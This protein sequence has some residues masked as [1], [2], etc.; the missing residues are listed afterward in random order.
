MDQP[1]TDPRPFRNLTLI[2][3]IACIGVLIGA[4]FHAQRLLTQFETNQQI[5]LTS[6]AT[7]VA[8]EARR[9]TNEFSHMLADFGARVIAMPEQQASSFLLEQVVASNVIRSLDVIDASGRIIASSV[10][11]NI[12]G[13]Y[14]PERPDAAALKGEVWWGPPRT[15]RYLSGSSVVGPLTEGFANFTFFTL[16]MQIGDRWVVMSIGGARFLRFYGHLLEKGGT[17]LALYTYGGKLIE[18]TDKGLLP[19]G[20]NPIFQRFI[21]QQEQGY[22]TYASRLSD[23]AYGAFLSPPGIPIVVF[24][25]TGDTAREQYLFAIAREVAL[26]EGVAFAIVLIATAALFIVYARDKRWSQALIA[27]NEE[28]WSVVRTNPGLIFKWR[29]SFDFR[30]QRFTFVGPQAATVLGVDRDALLQTA[31]SLRVVEQDRTAALEAIRWSFKTGTRL[32]LRLRM[33][34]NSPQ[35]VRHYRILAAPLRHTADQENELSGVAFDVTAEAMVQLSLEINH[36][37]SDAESVESALSIAEDR[38]NLSVIDAT[39]LIY[40]VTDKG[41]LL[42]PSALPMPAERPRMRAENRSGAILANVLSGDG[43]ATLQKDG[44]YVRNRGGDAE[45]GGTYALPVSDWWVALNTPDQG[46]IGVMCLNFLRW[47]N[48]QVETRQF[49]IDVARALGLVLAR[50]EASRQLARNKEFLQ[51]LTES[52]REGILVFGPDGRI[53]Y[54]TNAAAH[55]INLGLTDILG[56]TMAELDV[57]LVNERGKR[58]EMRNFR[59]TIR[60]LQQIGSIDLLTLGLRSRDGAVL[61]LEVTPNLLPGLNDDAEPRLLATI[62]DIT[63]QKHTRDRVKIMGQVMERTSQGVLVADAGNRVIMVNSGFTRITGYDEEEIVGSRPN[64]LSSGRHDKDFYRGMWQSLRDT[65][66]WAGEIQN[67]RKNGTIYPE[68]LSISEIRDERGR[69]MYRLGVFS[70]IS[71]IKSAQEQIADLAFYDQVTRLPNRV[72]L[73]ERLHSLLTILP[74]K[75]TV[76]AVLFIDLDRFKNV[77]DTLGHEVGDILLGKVAVRWR[78]L[79]RESDTLSRIGGDEFV[80]LLDPITSEHD[81]ALV[82]QK[83]IE[84]VNRPFEVGTHEIHVGC[85]VGIAICPQSHGDVDTVLREA[86]AAMYNAKANGRNRF[87]V[88]SEK[89]SE[90]VSHRLFIEGAIRNGLR[91]GW[92]E[93]Y[94]Q[95]KVDFSNRTQ[96]IGMEALVRMR[97]PVRGIIP[98]ADF[99][100]VAE[101]TG[102]ITELG[103]WCLQEA[104][105]MAARLIAAGYNDIPIAVNVSAVQFRHGGLARIALAQVEAAGVPPGSIELEVTETVIAEDLEKVVQE[106]H[107]VRSAGMGVAIDDFGSGYS[108]LSY[109]KSLPITTL[110]V[111][112]SFVSNI[113]RSEED[114]KIVLAIVDLARAL[115]LSIVAEGVE[116]AAQA[117]ALL[118]LGCR[119][120]QGYLFGRPMTESETLR[121]LENNRW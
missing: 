43:L 38:I 92:F 106:L 22:F 71:E 44:L 105:Q 5:G 113:A 85:S 65:G 33:A 96:P 57:Q 104:S 16:E 25:Y 29:E 55:M 93:L 59:A 116:T 41:A 52:L 121:W 112:R 100:S 118:R 6:G 24:A 91:H 54:A 115:G 78:G 117:D 79:L 53:E 75:K 17:E 77:N 64:I 34:P 30:R 28:Y 107:K 110:K 35:H 99:I 15:G 45:P 88:F 46:L 37:I 84:S 2:G 69:T 81:A 12:G 18:A 103:T 58:I 97:H 83:L 51:N 86:D 42:R 90:E 27:A 67:R 73:K 62:L 21:P 9:T 60:R 23:T 70:D 109:L 32:D 76:A 4:T 1:P 31:R 8:E 48:P 49:L 98:P 120:G 3:I 11:Q 108:S 26:S 114:S 10:Q 20:I 119:C 87:S 19:L 94:F 40:L 36:A 102:L 47:A 101:D 14:Q 74:R 56:R 72:L 111:D 13:I 39:C 68:W 50:F 95:P 63:D 80:V 66:H 89:L 61:W 7:L 82:A